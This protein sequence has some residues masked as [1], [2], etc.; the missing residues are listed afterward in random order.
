MTGGWLSGALCVLAS[1]SAGASLRSGAARWRRLWEIGAVVIVA[2]GVSRG[3]GVAALL[4]AIVAGFAGY[5]LG[6]PAANASTQAL[7]V[8]IAFV[9]WLLPDAPGLSGVFAVLAG[10]AVAALGYMVCVRTHRET[11]N[12]QPLHLACAGACAALAYVLGAQSGALAVVSV[13]AMVAL[14][15]AHLSLAMGGSASVPL[16]S[17]M[18][19]AASCGLAVA[20]AIGGVRG[21]NAALVVATVALAIGCARSVS[22]AG[23]VRE[24]P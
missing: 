10:G 14:I 2:Y 9:A 11:A 17:L 6:R 3:P 1:L 21:T 16:A 12:L 4:L 22:F 19:G 15:G 18:S 13:V 7:L 5:R 20:A 23:F 24:V 8:T